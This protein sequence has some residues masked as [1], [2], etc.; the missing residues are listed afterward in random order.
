MAMANSAPYVYD[1]GRHCVYCQHVVVRVFIPPRNGYARSLGCV[2]NR[3]HAG[4]EQYHVCCDF[5]REPGAD[6]ESLLLARDE[7]IPIRSRPAWEPSAFR[8]HSER[9]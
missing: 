6:D 5:R 9:R 3:G 2:K 1:P 8:A 7:S 4:E